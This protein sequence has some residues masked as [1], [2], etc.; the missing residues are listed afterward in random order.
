MVSLF[1]LKVWMGMN[2]VGSLR[3]SSPPYTFVL[4]CSLSSI[5]SCCWLFL[6]KYMT[7]SKS[8]DGQ[9]IMHAWHIQSLLVRGYPAVVV[10]DE[11][12]GLGFE[13]GLPVLLR[14]FIAKCH[15]NRVHIGDK[16]TP[17]LATLN[18]EAVFCNFCWSK[19]ICRNFSLSYCQFV[20]LG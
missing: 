3:F 16:T 5:C 1:L 7:A 18:C 19:I 4:S 13:A 11:T 10:V 20:N 9:C 2:V 17:T 12:D 8:Y 6:W 14:R 15:S